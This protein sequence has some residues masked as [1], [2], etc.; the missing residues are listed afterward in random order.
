MEKQVARRNPP[1]D[2]WQLIGETDIYDSLTATLNAIF[3][4][5]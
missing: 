5:Y 3:L 2:N 4:K 1:G